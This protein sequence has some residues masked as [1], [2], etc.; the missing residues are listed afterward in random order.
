MS[1]NPNDLQS[2][3][4]DTTSPLIWPRT[5]CSNYKTVI[6][7][8]QSTGYVDKADIFYQWTCD[9]NNPLYKRVNQALLNDDYRAL[10]EHENYINQ[11]RTAIR[12]SRSFESVKVYR[13]IKLQSND[14]HQ[15]KTNMVFLWPTFSSTSR[16]RQIAD[17]FGQY[18]FEIDASSND[19]TYRADISSFSKFAE[20]EILF[21]PYSGFRVKNVLKDA[22]VI[23][24]ECVD[25][26]KIESISDSSP[27]V[28]ASQQ[29][30]TNNSFSTHNAPAPQQS[31]TNNSFSTHN[32]RVPQQSY[33]NNSFS[34][35]T[36]ATPYCYTPN[37]VTIPAHTISMPSTQRNHICHNPAPGGF[38]LSPVNT[39]TVLRT[40]AKNPT[41]G[42][43]AFYNPQYGNQY[44]YRWN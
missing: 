43:N 13:G 37:I 40:P 36:P 8:K 2:R 35:P 31:Y 6:Q 28:P 24:L 32:V 30:Y 16:Q 26:L 34:T 18:L 33:T 7:S 23:Q 4:V 42:C 39:V 41:A 25:T 9:G 11:L 27:I 15:I 1:R 3:Y 44:H 12:E 29:S 17:G 20:A 22:K 38:Y 10:Q 21:Y 14:V 19:G 5:R